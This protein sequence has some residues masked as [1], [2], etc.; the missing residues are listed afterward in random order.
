MSID[1]KSEI[2]GLLDRN[3]TQALT[4]TTGLHPDLPPPLHKGKVR[5]TY[6]GGNGIL[7]TVATDRISTFD[8]VHPNGIPGKGILL[9]QSSARFFEILEGI[10]P[11]HYITTNLSQM[12]PPFRDIPQLEGR[13]TMVKK[14]DMVLV[15]AI[16]R[17]NITGSAWK[18]YEATGSVCGIKLPK[19]LQESQEF[20]EALFTPS[21]KAPAGT[22]DTNISFDQMT[23]IIA[24]QFP[25]L[26]ARET[27]QNLK[28]S[29]LLV[30]GLARD[31]AKRKGVIVADTKF[32][33]GFIGEVLTL[34][35]EVLTPDSSRFWDAQKFEAGRPQESFD[36]QVARNW[37]QSSGWDK[38]APAPELPEDIVR[39]TA[40]RYALIYERLWG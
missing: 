11:T 16:A 7:L 19:N 20:P 14:L 18:D 3:G 34:A 36:K 4:T 30:F 23:E 38:K 2:R 10:I 6:D 29:T 13:T 5:E 28:N 26:D 21:D 31:Y 15:E 12:P 17:G 24:K 32:E 40:Q 35:D 33:F 22:H 8:H 1:R 39:L 9:T 37:A 25:H 27:A